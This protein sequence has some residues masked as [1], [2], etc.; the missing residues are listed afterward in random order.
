MTSKLF[1]FGYGYSCDFIGRALLNK[2]WEVAGTTRDPQKKALMKEQG[3]KGFLYDEY[4]PLEDPALFLKNTTHLLLSVPPDDEGDPVFLHH[5]Q[6]ILAIDS[7]QWV[8]Y[9]SSTGVYGD[10]DGALVDENTEPRPINKRGSRRLKAEQQ[11]LSL[12]QR[13][14]LP[15]HIFRIAGIYGPAR[16][17]IDAVRA[18]NARRIHKQGHAFSRIHVDDIT[19]VLAA[20]MAQPAPGEIYNICDDR[21]SPSHEVIAHAC[22]LLGMEVPPLLDFDE[23]DMAPIARSFY[24]E[25]KRV[26]NR[27]IK[28]ELGV[29][30]KYPDYQSGLRACLAAE[31][32]SEALLPES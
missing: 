30:L 18:G 25:N 14:D 9:L 5:A 11:W 32:D 20:S 12:Q 15:V 22:E 28:E 21:A 16:S 31:E 26:S 8:G 10:R 29:V 13:H 6:D 7:L 1:C 2:G 4:S 19:G 3:I 27:K 17:A 24:A 23:I